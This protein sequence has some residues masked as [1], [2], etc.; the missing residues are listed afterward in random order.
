MTNLLRRTS[1]KYHHSSQS[2]QKYLGGNSNQEVKDLCD[3][4]FKTLRKETEQDNRR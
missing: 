1:E 3:H 2:T 4:N